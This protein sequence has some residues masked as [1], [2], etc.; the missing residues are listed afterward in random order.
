MK[1]LRTILLLAISILLCSDGGFADVK[2]KQRS[3]NSGFAG[4]AASESEELTVLVADKMKTTTSTRFTGGVVGFFAGKGPRI[5]TR[6]VRLDKELTWEIDDKEKSYKEIT[7]AQLRAQTQEAREK[8]K[9]LEKPEGEEEKPETR[10]NLKWDVKA[11]GEKK[12]INGFPCEHVIVALT[13]EEENLKTNEKRDVSFFTLDQWLA[14]GNEQAQAELEAF[15]MKMAQAMGLTEM[16]A[17][18][19]S[20]LMAQYGD[21]LKELREKAKD[22]KGYPIVSTVSIETV[23]ALQGEEREVKEEEQ[24]KPKVELPGGFGGLFGK[25]K[26]EKEEDKKEE[27]TAEAPKAKAGK[28]GRTSLFSMTTEVLELSTTPVS[29]SEFEVPAGY[30]KED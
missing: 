18:F 20:A 29:G 3:K 2:I 11:T 4:F 26:K 30:K 25:R 17:D 15:H 23:E 7:F 12:T 5:Q 1:P 8:M 14:A 28:P 9:G 19:M 21:Y 22:L 27:K 10:I 13:V 16:G 6:I 24:Q